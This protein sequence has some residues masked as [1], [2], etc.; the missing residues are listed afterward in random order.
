MTDM[1]L[2]KNAPLGVWCD[3]RVYSDA[4]MFLM[5]FAGAC[6]SETICQAQLNMGPEP[7]LLMSFNATEVNALM[8]LNTKKDL[9]AES[10]QFRELVATLFAKPSAAPKV[11]RTVAPTQAAAPQAKKAAAPAPAPTAATTPPTFG[12]TAFKNLYNTGYKYQKYFKATN[13]NAYTDDTGYV[14]QATYLELAQ[15]MKARR[16][17]A[18]KGGDAKKAPKGID[19]NLPRPKVN[20]DFLQRMGSHRWGPKSQISPDRA[21]TWNV[22][23]KT[24][25]LV[26]TLINKKPY[27]LARDARDF[28][29]GVRLP[30][31]YSILVRQPMA[32]DDDRAQCGI[33]SAE[34]VQGV[35]GKDWCL[36]INAFNQVS[37]LRGDA[38]DCTTMAWAPVPDDI[39]DSLAPA[40]TVKDPRADLGNTWSEIEA[41]LKRL[42][43]VEGRL[44]LR[45]G[46]TDS[47]S[48]LCLAFGPTEQNKDAHLYRARCALN[49]HQVF[50]KSGPNM[51]VALRSNVSPPRFKLTRIELQVGDGSAQRF[52]VLGVEENLAQPIEQPRCS[53][54]ASDTFAPFSVKCVGD[55]F[56][57]FTIKNQKALCDMKIDTD[58]LL[59]CGDQPTKPSLPHLFLIRGSSTCEGRAMCRATVSHAVDASDNR[60]WFDLQSGEFDLARWP[61][62]VPLWN[63][64]LSN[65]APLIAEDKL[66]NQVCLGFVNNTVQPL[67]LKVGKANPAAHVMIKMRRSYGTVRRNIVKLPLSRRS[68]CALVRARVVSEVPQ[69]LPGMGFCVK[70]LLDDAFFVRDTNVQNCDAVQFTSLNDDNVIGTIVSHP[71]SLCLTFNATS[72]TQDADTSALYL[73]KC[74]PARAQYQTFMYGTMSGRL[75]AL[76]ATTST[77]QNNLLA[78]ARKQALASGNGKAKLADLSNEDV[79]R[80]LADPGLNP[81]LFFWWRGIIRPYVTLPLTAQSSDYYSWDIDTRNIAPIIARDV[82]GYSGACLMFGREISKSP[83]LG[84]QKCSLFR[85]NT[86]NPNTQTPATPGSVRLRVDSQCVTQTILTSRLDRLQPGDR[87]LTLQPCQSADQADAAASQRFVMSTQSNTPC[88]GAACNNLLVRLAGGISPD[89]SLI[90]TVPRTTNAVSNV[91]GRVLPGYSLLQMGSWSAVDRPL[92]KVSLNTPATIT[93]VSQDQALLETNAQGLDSPDQVAAPQDDVAQPITGGCWQ[94]VDQVLYYSK[95]ASARCLAVVVEPIRALDT[96]VPSSVLPVSVFRS[97]AGQTVLGTFFHADLG[98]SGT[99]QYTFQ[100]SSFTRNTDGS[101]DINFTRERTAFLLPAKF[102]RD[103]T[104]SAP[105]LPWATPNLAQAPQFSLVKFTWAWKRTLAPL[106]GQSYLLMSSMRHSGCHLYVTSDSN[107]GLTCYKNQ[108]PIAKCAT[109]GI[110][111]GTNQSTPFNFFSHNPNTVA[112][113]IS[114]SANTPSSV[115]L[116]GQQVLSCAMSADWSPPHLNYIQLFDDE[117]QW[118]FRTTSATLFE[119]AY[120]ES[121]SQTGLQ[122]LATANPSSVLNA[123]TRG[124]VRTRWELCTPKIVN[125]RT[126]SV[127]CVVRFVDA[128]GQ[129]TN[130]TLPASSLSLACSRPGC[131]L[132]VVATSPLSVM[133]QPKYPKMFTSE[134]QGASVWLVDEARLTDGFSMQAFSTNMNFFTVSTQKDDSM[135]ITTKPQSNHKWTTQWDIAE[136]RIPDD[137]TST[138]NFS[139][140]I[141]ATKPFSMYGLLSIKAYFFDTESADGAVPLTMVQGG[142]VIYSGGPF[143]LRLNGTQPSFVAGRK[144]LVRLEWYSPGAKLDN[145]RFNMNLEYVKTEVP[146]FLQV[147]LKQRVETVA[148]FTAQAHL[149]AESSTEVGLRDSFR[150]M[151]LDSSPRVWRV[152]SGNEDVF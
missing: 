41:Q 45:D 115:Y 128:N 5:N 80:V 55:E 93:P 142:S 3:Q 61:D 29:V 140:V 81:I 117:S 127:R 74:D 138:R 139:F 19:P 87:V 2:F 94:V 60:V 68:Q 40:P 147:D 78:A 15:S 145:V 130:T 18:R 96:S 39:F 22:P 102:A 72:L 59:M 1:E 108:N 98:F 110:W 33:F 12:Y 16:S 91:T 121:S 30:E 100:G 75:R 141:T 131:D 97:S 92:W 54:Q 51:Y 119:A 73:D 136:V 35:A 34:P 53:F 114:T 135:R 38:L 144:Y 134:D 62:L 52:N 6:R 49:R 76:Q 31:A 17:R 70:T 69:D 42:Q 11:K 57:Q 56:A 65:F 95:V 64:S 84:N 66:G 46:V 89:V 99:Q 113:L 13:K 129:L 103:T 120:Y 88:S 67:L 90:W 32:A 83:V 123:Q 148:L 4:E 146:V 132:Q 149:E 8:T 124:V 23:Y 152:D 77:F 101:I 58:G 26:T 133:Y 79:K 43:A 109:Q 107:L 48:N 150:Y 63:V 27:C 47:Y 36:S 9:A 44:Q 7:R 151:S 125:N 14:D 71:S 112:V 111:I 105:R 82:R 118:Q 122:D 116:N 50:Y 137:Y 104:G 37:W 143:S 10:Q 28:G 24:W 126:E 21:F 20:Q 25:G 86:L 106:R 85:F